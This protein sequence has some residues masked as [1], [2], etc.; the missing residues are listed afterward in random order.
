[1]L[2]GLGNIG[3][4]MTSIFKRMFVI[5]TYIGVLLSLFAIH[6]YLLLNDGSLASHIGFSFLNAWALAKVILVGQEMRIG[7][8]F[9]NSPLIYNIAFK[10]AT[11]AILLLIFRIIEEAVIGAV[12]GKN[13]HDAVFSDHPGLENNVFQGMVLTCVIMFFALMPFFAYLELA[14]MLGDD[15]MSTMMFGGASEND[16]PQDETLAQAKGMGVQASSLVGSTRA[17]PE[18]LMREG[19][20]VSTS[21]RSQEMSSAYQELWYYERAG[22]VMGPVSERELSRLLRLGVIGPTTLVH[23]VSGAEGWRLIQETALV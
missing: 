18:D 11:F 3:A 20:P 22:E 14:R 15:Q 2:E 1:M 23:N 16:P 5:A 19:V 9:R 8:R 13:I 4:R 7:D 17:D 6:R 21:T 10:S 12:H